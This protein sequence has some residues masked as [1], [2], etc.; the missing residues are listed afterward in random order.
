MFD[1]LEVVVEAATVVV[2]A[3]GLGDGADWCVCGGS[4]L[5]GVS[6]TQLAT[7]PTTNLFFSFLSILRIPFD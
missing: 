3:V 6:A 4:S 5:Y 7:R 1:V 2:V